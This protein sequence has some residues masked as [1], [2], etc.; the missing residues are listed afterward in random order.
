M[1][2]LDR[3]YT[4]GGDAGQTS[5]GDGARVA[6]HDPRVA[7]FGEVDEANAAIGIARNLAAADGGGQL[8]DILGAIQNDLFDLG[9]D[10]C[11][12]ADRPGKTTLRMLESHVT[13]LET[14]IDAA[15]AELQPLQSFI[16]PGGTAL[17]AHLHLART[18]TRRAE[19]AMTALAAV[20]PVNTQALIYVNRLSDLLF[21]LARQANDRGRAD[22][23]WRPGGGS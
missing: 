16:L 20:E 9:A 3:I 10:L 22:I 13:R 11:V 17:A 19:R 14:A 18:V 23:L 6:K 12:P 1:V 15:N 2:R 7:A 21:V 5:L 4:G 8:A